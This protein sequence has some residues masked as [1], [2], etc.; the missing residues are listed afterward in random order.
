MVF[1]L[2][3]RRIC[4]KTKCEESSFQFLCR[5]FISI[6]QSYLRQLKVT[7]TKLCR[8]FSDFSRYNSQ[9]F[10]VSGTEGL[11]LSHFYPTSSSAYSSCLSQGSMRSRACSLVISE[12]FKNQSLNSQK[13]EL[14][15]FPIGPSLPEC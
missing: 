1:R 14:L 8:F 3:C 7:D 6:K 15:F 9:Y 11:L 13:N 5:N 10:I 12:R 2:L 4:Y